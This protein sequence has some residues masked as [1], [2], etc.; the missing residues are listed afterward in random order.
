MVGG[1]IEVGDRIRPI[2]ETM[3]TS[4]TRVGEVGSAHAM[5]ALNNLEH[6]P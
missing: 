3:G 2:L 6:F 4:V 1:D 5:K